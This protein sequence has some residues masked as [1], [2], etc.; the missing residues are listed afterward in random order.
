MI[1]LNGPGHAMLVGE[2][3]RDREKR[4]SIEHVV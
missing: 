2:R 3:E 4:K 1:A